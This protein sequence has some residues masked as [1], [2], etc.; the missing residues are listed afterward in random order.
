MTIPL[1][2]RPFWLW[3]Q[4]LCVPLNCALF[5]TILVESQQMNIL[6]PSGWI[7]IQSI[8]ATFHMVWFLMFYAVVGVSTSKRRTMVDIFPAVKT[9]FYGE[10]INSILCLVVLSMA[11]VT[12][13]EKARFIEFLFIYLLAQLSIYLNYAFTFW[14]IDILMFT[15]YHHHRNNDNN[16]N[17]QQ[18]LE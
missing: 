9:I 16:N 6:A 7:V 13:Q 17:H 12:H 14:R 1:E 3:H 4:L 8:V 10:A 15:R 11:Y 18:S 2:W 5:V